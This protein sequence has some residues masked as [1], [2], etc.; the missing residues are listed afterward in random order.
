[1][2]YSLLADL[3]VLLHALFV[4]FVIFGGLAVLRRPRLAWLHLP[5]AVWGTTIEFG[6][7]VCPLTYLENYLRYRGGAASYEGSCIQHYLEPILYPLGLTAR[8]QVIMGVV[9]LGINIAVYIR[10]WRKRTRRS[11]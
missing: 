2:F 8:S 6:G 10:L 4:L 5:A 7:W 11:G 3:T 9:V 1:M